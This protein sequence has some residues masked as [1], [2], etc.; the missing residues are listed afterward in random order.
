M[1][2]INQ[3]EVCSKCGLGKSTMYKLISEGKFPPPIKVTGTASRWPQAAITQ[4]T[5]ERMAEAGY[6]VEVQP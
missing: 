4:W 2:F 5:T 3:S 6:A 1:K